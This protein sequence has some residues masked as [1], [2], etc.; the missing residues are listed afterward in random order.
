[1]NDRTL[2]DIIKDIDNVLYDKDSENLED[3]ASLY[4]IPSKKG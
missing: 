3:L 4:D 1:M 2:K